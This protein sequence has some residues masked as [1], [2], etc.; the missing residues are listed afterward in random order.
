MTM[1]G[2]DTEGTVTIWGDNNQKRMECK[3]KHSDVEIG[4]GAAAGLRVEETPIL[5]SG[6]DTPQG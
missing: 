6:V 5:E 4:T 2:K 3:S 1:D